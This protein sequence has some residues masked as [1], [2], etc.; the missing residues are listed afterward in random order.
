MPYSVLVPII[1]VAPAVD[2]RDH[3]SSHRLIILNIHLAKE[4]EELMMSG[5][6]SQIRLCSTLI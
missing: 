6:Q 2:G 4:A 3:F 1:S 5:N